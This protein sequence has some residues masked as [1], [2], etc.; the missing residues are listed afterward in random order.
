VGVAPRVVDLA[1]VVDVHRHD[2]DRPALAAGAA[3][4]HLEAVLE[5][6]VV[7]HARERVAQREVL[8]PLARLVELGV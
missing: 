6:A 5:G 4:L 2:R 1:E 3:Q 8:Q 7:E